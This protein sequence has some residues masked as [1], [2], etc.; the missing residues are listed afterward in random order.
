MMELLKNF[1]KLERIE[2]YIDPYESKFN[3]PELKVTPLV[4]T[5]FVRS[6]YMGPFRWRKFQISGSK[7]G[8][9]DLGSGVDRPWQYYLTGNIDHDTRYLKQKVV[10]C[11]NHYFNTCYGSPGSR[12]ILLLNHKIYFGCTMFIRRNGESNWIEEN[13]LSLDDFE[14][15]LEIDPDSEAIIDD[16]IK[17][18]LKS[19]YDYFDI[20]AA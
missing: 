11:I 16:F 17:A 4:T 9:L 1:V 20:K 12:T 19:Y 7:D 14:N 6:G 18:T 10:E 5:D 15:I 13:E 3:V 2:N 8:E